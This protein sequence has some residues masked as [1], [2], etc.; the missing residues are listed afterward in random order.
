[1]K[2]AMVRILLAEDHTII[3]K[4]MRQIL[5]DALPQAQ[6]E[7]IGEGEE[8]DERLMDCRWDVIISDQQGFGNR[9]REVF[10]RPDQ[11]VM[12]VLLLN[13]YAHEH[14]GYRSLRTGAA[15]ALGRD[16]AADELIWAVRQILSGKK[17]LAIPSKN[18]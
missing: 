9:V 12:P 4:G 6:I 13:L 8:W 16:A 5:T 7:E 1:M 14:H 2:S 10:Q 15:G 17:Y 3:R 18:N 11:S